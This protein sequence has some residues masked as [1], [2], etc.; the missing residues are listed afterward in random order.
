M[1]MKLIAG[2]AASL[3]CMLPV[4]C[5]AEEQR[6][7][8][9]SEEW[10]YYQ[11][12][13]GTVTI[14]GWSG[15]G[16]K[17]R[18]PEEIDSQP[19]T[20]IGEEAFYACTGLTEISIPES[21]TEIGKHAFEYCTSLEYMEIP[22]SVEEIED[23]A[24]QFCEGL[25][26]V[27][28]PESVTRIGKKAFCACNS[29]TNIVIP[30]SVEEIGD[31]AFGTCDS[32]TD[33][34]VSPENAFYT[35]INKSLV[36][37]ETMTLVCYPAGLAGSVYDIPDGIVKIGNE[38][39]MDCAG[40]TNVTIPGSV[41]EIGEYAFSFCHGLKDIKIPESVTKIGAFA[42]SNCAG[43]ESVSIPESVTEIGKDA[44]YGCGKLTLPW[45]A[46][47]SA[48]NSFQRPEEDNSKMM[49]ANR[50]ER[51]V[52]VEVNG[53]QGVCSEGDYYWVSGSATLSKYD[54]DWNLIAEN[55]D[56]FEGYEI[57]VNHIGDIDVYQN[58]LYIGAEYFMDGVGKN[59]Q[60]AVY[61]G[62][63]LRLKR[64]FPFE[65]E[66]G[67]ME[68]A[69][70]AVDPDTKT[71]WMCSWVGEESGRYLYRYDLETGTYLGKIHLQMPPQWLQGI[72]YYDGWFYMTADD[73]NADDNE[74][75]HLYRTKIEDG[76]TS[77]TVTL[78]RTFDDVIRQGEIEGLTFDREH[79][80][81]LILYNRGARIVL[82]MP[83]GFY[84]GY[85]REISEVITYRLSAFMPQ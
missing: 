68:C 57:E 62:D 30:D 81:L 41:V 8:L 48:E 63:T 49:P 54:M 46:S 51:I 16:E 13:D 4:S 36:E 71:V 39:F 43:L 84:D 58:E 35:V 66:S 76:L 11:N 15:E 78:E 67:Q 5:F 77:C 10:E 32:L 61:D 6:D 45:D 50:Y 55:N 20:G 40:L 19:V 2:V 29:L 34:E 69:G 31:W 59:I 9:H 38:A 3:I 73:G 74:P 75:D 60:I 64:T 24:F 28:I 82:G 37:K 56:P 65:P 80:Q 33:I 72:A 12:D 53:R 1:K 70:I 14:S 26:G 7:I 23:F 44:F 47:G 22:D 27:T 21:V 17:I 79:G 25:R 85:D 83:E 42:F 52:S 18:I